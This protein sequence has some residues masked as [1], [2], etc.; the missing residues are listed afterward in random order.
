[1]SKEALKNF[2]THWL[3]YKKSFWLFFSLCR[4]GSWWCC[5]ISA[6]SHTLILAEL[7]ARGC[8]AIAAKSDLVLHISQLQAV[9]SLP[10][11]SVLLFIKEL[12]PPMRHPP[13]QLLSEGLFS[14][15][16]HRGARS[17]APAPWYGAM[18]TALAEHIWQIV[19][20][21]QQY[22]S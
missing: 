7:R 11:V 15:H 10:D 21:E 18:S 3:S 20:R 8:I 1:M 16:H 6:A 9:P 19:N 17:L 22:G 4:C 5:C 14:D 13:P 12:R 2:S